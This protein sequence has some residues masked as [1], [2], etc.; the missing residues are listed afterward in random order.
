M[1]YVKNIIICCMFVLQTICMAVAPKT[2]VVN[3]IPTYKP[4]PE[5]IKELIA[6]MRTAT[7]RE[8]ID[9]GNIWLIDDADPD[10]K[11]RNMI[12]ESTREYWP[13]GEG[14]TLILCNGKNI[15]IGFTR[16]ML[17][18]IFCDVFKSNTNAFCMFIDSDDILAPGMIDFMLEP[19]KQYGDSKYYVAL[20]EPGLQIFS[21]KCPTIDVDQKC[22]IEC[23]PSPL[24]IP[25][26]KI[27]PIRFNEDGRADVVE[28]WSSG[29]CPVM[30]SVET[31]KLCLPIRFGDDL[32]FV[33][34]HARNNM[35]HHI[36]KG[37][38]FPMYLIKGPVLYFYRCNIDSHSNKKV[39]HNFHKIYELIHNPFCKKAMS[40]CEVERLKKMFLNVSIRF[41]LAP[42]REA[43]LSDVKNKELVESFLGLLP[44]LRIVDDRECGFGGWNL[45][46]FIID[47]S[48]SLKHKLLSK[49]LFDELCT[50]V[51]LATGSTAF[52]DIEHYYDRAT[53]LA[54][55]I[56]DREPELKSIDKDYQS[57]KSTACKN[58]RSSLLSSDTR[59]EMCEFVKPKKKDSLRN[60]NGCPMC[61]YAQRKKQTLFCVIKQMQGK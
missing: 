43:F 20:G 42:W 38:T 22:S 44:R 1:V 15:G 35:G 24:K 36:E 37:K 21:G 40:E 23:I 13:A 49:T 19:L 52:G 55:L 17:L 29:Y 53:A 16:Y 7:F 46:L 2:S 61:E 59:C 10:D 45:S 47:L 9:I 48:F 14:S 28:S 50:C 25:E 57:I 12:M 18:K 58:M 33:V 8:D 54:M 30:M 11:I 34:E 60:A 6:S 27:R 39:I 26:F 51:N 31:A 56:R 32:L 5:H 4:N 41:A 3:L